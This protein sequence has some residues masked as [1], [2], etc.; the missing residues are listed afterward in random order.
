M[1]R[2]S[3]SGSVSAEHSQLSDEKMTDDLQKI[4]TDMTKL[5]GVASLQTIR[6]DPHQSLDEDKE[7]LAGDKQNM[8]RGETSGVCKEAPLEK[9]ASPIQGQTAEISSCTGVI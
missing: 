4:F 7:K 2:F 8:T 9:Q 1:K 3:S 5:E 6:S